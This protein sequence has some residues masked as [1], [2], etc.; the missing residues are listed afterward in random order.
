MVG[1]VGGE[2]G[3]LAAVIAFVGDTVDRVG[4]DRLGLG[5]ATGDEYGSQHACLANLEHGFP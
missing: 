1:Q 3:D 5:A 2:G 4:V